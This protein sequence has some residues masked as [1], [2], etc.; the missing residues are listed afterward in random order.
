[1]SGGRCVHELGLAENIAQI[2]R[3]QLELHGARRVN[4]IRI[5]IGD[6]V[7]VDPAALQFGFEITVE[8]DPELEHA[9][10]EIEHVPH[11]ARCRAC[12]SEYTI[13]DFDASCPQCGTYSVDVISGNE[14]QVL[15]M[16]IDQD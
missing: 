10:L 13:V 9:V 15:E 12:T 4:V 5:L 8:S 11:R 16:D 14:F 6:A 3:R 2:A 1:M 7:A